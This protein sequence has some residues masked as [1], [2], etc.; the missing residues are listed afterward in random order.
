[1]QFRQ[2]LMSSLA[3]AAILSLCGALPAL[4]SPD[5]TRTEIINESVGFPGVCAAPCYSVEKV[6]DFYLPG[7][8]SA[9]GPNCGAGEN[10]FV[11]TLTHIGGTIPFPSIPVTEFEIVAPFS[12][13]VSATVIGSLDVN[14]TSTTISPLDTISW[15]FPQTPACTAAPGSWPRRHELNSQHDVRDEIEA[16]WPWCHLA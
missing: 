2:F 7:N 15:T 14:A 6:S 3:A 16:R 9:P 12:E 13:V 11:Y 5:L 10:T 1:M 4:A 8:G